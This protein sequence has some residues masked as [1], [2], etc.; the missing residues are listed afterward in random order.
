MG[1]CDKSTLDANGMSRRRFLAGAGMS[2]AALGLAS[3]GISGCSS[4]S[5][6]SGK[7][8]SLDY[9][10][11]IPWDA[12]YD[13]VVVGFGG[14][15]AASA[16]SA[17]DA[18]AKVLLLEKAPLGDE[19]G[20][21]RY[22]EQAILWF[23]DYDGGVK[24]MKNM[25]AGFDSATD[26]VIDYMVKGSMDNKEW[27]LSLG[28]ESVGEAPM[29]Q[30]YHFTMD[31]EFGNWLT[32]DG[33]SFIEY[34]ERIMPGGAH[35]FIVNV[36]SQI[37]NGQKLYWK[38]MR[39]NVVERAESIDV[40]FESPALNLLQD[41]FSKT[42]LGVK[43][44]HAGA[45]L[46]VRAKNGVILSCGSYEASLD[47]FQNYACYPKAYPMG[48]LYNT[49]DGIDMAIQAGANLWHMASLSGPWLAPKYPDADRTYFL[50]MSQR[51]T[52]AGNCINVGG[53]G[54]RFVAEC[55]WQKHGHI[56]Y[57]GS[58]KS[59]M[60]P[61]VMYTIFD[62]TAMSKGGAGIGVVDESLYFK[63][64]TIEAL[65]SAIDIDATTLAATVA[66]YNGYVDAGK[67]EQFDRNPS[68]LARIETSPFYAVRL[69]P[70][71]VNVQ[72][73]PRRNTD[74]EVL[75][76]EGNAIPHLYS[77]GELGSFWNDVYCG[78]GNIAETMYTGRTAGANAAAEKE[79]VPT[80]KI[81]LVSSN[82]KEL[83]SDLDTSATA[84]VQLGENEYLGTGQGLHGDVVVK[85]KVENGKPT[86]IEVVEEHETE[87][88]TDAV[89]ATMPDSMIAAGTAN[90][91]TIAG[92]TLASKGL[93]EAVNDAISQ[94]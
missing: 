65:A 74:C 4:E 92:A 42:V 93:I 31:S 5:S 84:D 34:P 59:Q 40:W 80:A 35:S 70:G 12:E 37:D 14:A 29:A 50:G 66:R 53:D 27:L 77:A 20:N 24:Y 89:W 13:V 16:I 81:A 60:C 11:T 23:D 43:A 51:Y 82:V 76:M 63:A 33:T 78:G 15:G 17:A 30:A 19:G 18:G 90:V 32:D 86:A 21:T 52:N 88:I 55:G 38:L 57:S 2:A 47:K 62:Q 9:A 71:C 44:Q 91:D 73:G 54:T 25:T 45:E 94:A 22:C 68:T 58:W 85:V 8:I 6:G 46:N 48:S 87:G 36:G 61:D 72:G 41:P 67:D 69:Y 75:D 3:L 39:K 1:E 64:D 7:T 56:D 28:A 83:G 26:E 79:E 10:K 49:G